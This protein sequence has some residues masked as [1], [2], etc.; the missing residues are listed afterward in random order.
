M[1]NPRSCPKECEKRRSKLK[2]YGTRKRRRRVGLQFQT[3]W[4]GG[5]RKEEDAEEDEEEEEIENVEE[6]E[7]QAVEEGSRCWEKICS[8]E[9]EARKKTS[10]KRGCD[11]ASEIK[12]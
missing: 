5:G 4:R 8:V 7:C 12:P 9:E 1:K 3:M 10:F 6:N 2:S 11:T